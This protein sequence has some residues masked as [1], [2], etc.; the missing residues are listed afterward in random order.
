MP[1][2]LLLAAVVALLLV[3]G[4]QADPPASKVLD[5][6]GATPSLALG[7]EKFAFTRAGDIHVRRAD[8]TGETRLTT[9]GVA[10][11]ELVWSPDQSRLAWTQGG[12]ILSIGADG[13]G[14]VNLTGTAATERA[15]N[16]S[17]DG[18][19]IAFTSNRDGSDDV[20]VAP[21]GGGA[22]MNVSRLAGTERPGGWSAGGERL[23]L[24]AGTA[25]WNTHLWTV[26]PD[27]S[28]LTHLSRHAPLGTV[29]GWSPNATQVYYFDEPWIYRA[30]GTTAAPVPLANLGGAWAYVGP[31]GIS[32]VSPDGSRLALETTDGVMMV[33]LATGSVSSLPLPGYW[34]DVYFDSW[35]PDGREV[36][37]HTEAGLDDCLGARLF[38]AAAD[39][40]DARQI[41][42]VDQGGRAPG[43]WSP[44]GGTFYF[45]RLY[46]G[47]CS[48][49]HLQELYA[50]PL[51]SAEYPADGSLHDIE[52]SL[53]G[54]HAGLSTGRA[55]ASL[56][57]ALRRLREAIAVDGWRADGSPLPNG[58][59]AQTLSLLNGSVLRL[60]GSQV[61]LRSASATERAQLVALMRAWA[62]TRIA[63]VEGSGANAPLKRARGYLAS[64]DALRDAN[65]G[66][67]YAIFGRYRRAWTTLL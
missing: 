34:Y 62:S 25:S 11:A 66:A 15:P 14:F 26:Q 65:P 8:G 17:P 46:L 21:A 33:D 39:G 31:A 42:T 58:A 44:D 38:T 53:E 43:S 47:F 1:R 40:S 9:D 52:S 2:A 64:G 49:A 41:A 27:G 55:R 28:A 30:D 19:R 7:N 22:A 10:K 45:K 48:V 60:G 50:V 18:S 36:A 29:V 20:F 5:W 12:D 54:L 4:S 57:I 23:L 13:T 67:S 59:G 51:G 61:E 6:S 56:N 63:E 24:L 35:S 37:F 3:P 32:D 16:W